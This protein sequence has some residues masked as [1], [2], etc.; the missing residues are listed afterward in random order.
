MTTEC[1]IPGCGKPTK[2]RGL[3]DKHYTRMMRHGDPMSV[4]VERPEKGDPMNFYR[5]FVLP[6][7]GDD[8]LIWP[9]G[10]T[11]NGYGTM[12]VDG[13]TVLVHRRVCE[14][15]NGAPP[16]PDH[17]AAHSCGKGKHGCVTKGHL[18]WKTHAD[19]QSDKIH[20]GTH[21][22]GERSNFSRLTE[23]QAREVLALKGKEK[24][25]SIAKR[26]GVSPQAISD[27]HRRKKWAWLDGSS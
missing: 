2:A 13:K 23:V 12:H 20:H 5:N 11:G 4:K 15:E 1:S 18:S 26:Y 8:C 19:N 3:C 6:Y 24:Q 9:F 17:E 21:S 10:R 14:D 22:R 7:E 16:T 25:N 27:I